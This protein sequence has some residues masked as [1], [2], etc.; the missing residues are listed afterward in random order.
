ML[1]INS[2]VCCSSDVVKYITN[3]HFGR[4]STLAELNQAIKVSSGS[5]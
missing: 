5:K 4:L 1:C 2:A 3:F